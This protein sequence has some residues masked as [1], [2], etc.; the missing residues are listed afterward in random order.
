MKKENVKYFLL[1]LL[2]PL[3][4]GR[5]RP[6][7]P[8]I[9]GRNRHSL[10]GFQEKAGDTLSGFVTTPSSFCSRTALTTRA[11]VPEGPGEPTSRAM[12]ALL[13]ARHR[14]FLQGPEMKAIRLLSRAVHQF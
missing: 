3:S 9:L 4:Y 2:I 1:L 8:W 10:A 11:A 13:G 6:S 7:S 14:A 12:Q 5:W